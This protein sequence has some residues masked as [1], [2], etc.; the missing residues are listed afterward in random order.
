MRK[1]AAAAGDCLDCFEQRT[2]DALAAPVGAHGQ[3][4]D[5]ALRA[6]S[7]DEIEHVVADQ[8]DRLA[9]VHVH[10]HAGVVAIEK[11]FEL[12]GGGVSIGRVSERAEQAR[13]C[14]RIG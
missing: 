14:A 9:V 13:D 3:C 4:R 1:H 5:P 12:R 7:V 10:E 6:R 8:P 2:R 11:R